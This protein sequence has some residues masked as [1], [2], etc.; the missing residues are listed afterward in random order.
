[1]ECSQNLRCHSYTYHNPDG[2]LKTAKPTN[3]GY[4]NNKLMLYRTNT[5][6]I[7]KDHHYCLSTGDINNRVYDAIDRSDETLF[8][9]SSKQIDYVALLIP[10]GRGSMGENNSYICNGFCQDLHNWCAGHNETC[11][12]YSP[13][14]NTDDPALCGDTRL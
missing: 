5:S 13:P 14:I 10:C 9:N 12:D 6:E 8:T 7:A 2:A 4:F 3:D 1:M 11:T